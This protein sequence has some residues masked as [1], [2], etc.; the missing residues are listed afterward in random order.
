ML[1]AAAAAARRRVGDSAGKLV[2]GCRIV[3]P[4]QRRRRIRHS[5]RNRVRR[6][7]GV[8]GAQRRIKVVRVAVAQHAVVVA[9]AAGAGAAAGALRRLPA[10]VVGPI[11][12]RRQRHKREAAQPAA[13]AAATAAIAAAAGRAAKAGLWRSRGRGCG[14]S[15]ADTGGG[16]SGVGHRWRGASRLAHG[17]WHGF[18]AGLLR[19]RCCCCLKWWIRSCFA[20]SGRRVAR[21]SVRTNSSVG[22]A[23]RSARSGE[24]RRTIPIAAAGRSAERSQPPVALAAASAISLHAP[25]A[26]PPLPS[27]AAA[28]AAEALLSVV[29][30]ISLICDSVRAP[31]IVVG[32]CALCV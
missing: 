8:G 31:R 29:V 10:P 27:A 6:G 2:G 13:A 21:C 26:L 7:H 20:L 1:V 12:G 11:A 3:V 32:L 9:L 24:R 16:C 28:A 25:A 19:R 18:L 22:G 5:I 30:E 15:G 4:R 17:G 23:T 14:R